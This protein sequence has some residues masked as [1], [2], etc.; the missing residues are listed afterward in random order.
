MHLNLV[1]F[2]A[3]MSPIGVLQDRPLSQIDAERLPDDLVTPE[4]DTSAGYV[5]VPESKAFHVSE[6]QTFQDGLATGS[7]AAFPMLRR[8]NPSCATVRPESLGRHHPRG[9]F[10]DGFG[11]LNDRR[12]L[13]LMPHVPLAVL[14]LSALDR[15]R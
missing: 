13:Q 2:F 15:D 8:H 4:T 10:W 9:Q 11:S 7:Y 1:N 5:S 6:K 3:G 14:L 12:S